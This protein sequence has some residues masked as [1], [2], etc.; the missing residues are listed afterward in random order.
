MGIRATITTDA[1]GNKGRTFL[2]TTKPEPVELPRAA[3]EQYARDAS[4][5]YF[6]NPTAREN[7]CFNL[8]LSY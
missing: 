3:L 2:K 1:Q 5:D 8:I 6:N 4:Y 7:F